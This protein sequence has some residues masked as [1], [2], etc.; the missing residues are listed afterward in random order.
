[1]ASSHHDYSHDLSLFC[2]QTLFH[3]SLLSS[4]AN[5]AAR[6]RPQRANNELDVFLMIFLTIHLALENGIEPGKFLKSGKVT[7]FE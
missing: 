2:F 3:P 7:L 6:Q 5:T 4:G 1:M